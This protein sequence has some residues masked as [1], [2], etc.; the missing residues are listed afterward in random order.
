MLA[1]KH[2]EF[3]YCDW[4]CPPRNLSNNKIKE[5]REGTFDG[6]SGVQELILTENQLESVHGRMFRGLTGLKTL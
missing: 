6:A 3:S 1:I 4:L 2:Y 5:I